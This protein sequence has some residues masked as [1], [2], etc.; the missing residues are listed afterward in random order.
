MP[1]YK[2]MYFKLFNAVTDAVKIL[3][4]AQAE[5]EELFIESSENDDKKVVKLEITEKKRT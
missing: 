1:D 3:S 2:T 5:A 4:E